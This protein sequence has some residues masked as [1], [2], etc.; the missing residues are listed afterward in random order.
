M[1]NAIIVFYSPM[2][3]ETIMPESRDP[4][5]TIIIIDIN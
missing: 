5:I 1:S 2:V 3:L 4:S